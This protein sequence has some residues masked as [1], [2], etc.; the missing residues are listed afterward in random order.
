MSQRPVPTIVVILAGGRAT[1]F[2][3]QDKGEIL[4]DG[5]RLID[6]IHNRL[7]PQSDEFILSGTHH[8]NLGMPVVPDREDAPCGPVGGLY[9]IWS[10][11]KGRDVEGF[12]TSAVDGPNVPADLLARLY[13]KSASTIAV[14]EKGRHPTYAWWRMK[15]LSSLWESL[16]MKDS[17]SLKRLA[18]LTKAENV[19][20]EGDKTFININRP[21]DLQR[22]VKGA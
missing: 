7:K 1:R 22:F 18:E 4:I 5:E 11:L 3:G 21:D 13:N 20:W 8:Y 6:I 17:L 2:G 19:K 12:F 10:Y 9:S 14:D 16:D 15:D